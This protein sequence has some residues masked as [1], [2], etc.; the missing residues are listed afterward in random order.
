MLIRSPTQVCRSRRRLVAIS[1]VAVLLLYVLSIGPAACLRKSVDTQWV[2][3]IVK[4]VYAPL[5]LLEKTVLGDIIAEYIEIFTPPPELNSEFRS[6]LI[7]KYIPNSTVVS[8]HGAVSVSWQ[9]N[10]YSLLNVPQK[11]PQKKGFRYPALSELLTD[12]RIPVR[13]G[14]SAKDL[15][16]MSQILLFGS[17]LNEDWSF[18][19][20]V[21]TGNVW[22]VKTWYSGPP[23]NAHRLTSEVLL[24]CLQ[25]NPSG[26]AT[27]FFIVEGGAEVLPTKL[28]P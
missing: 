17:G 2:D 13:D 10:Q 12:A 26:L 6:P 4:V 1:V 27:N 21:Q 9:G 25:T 7:D 15:V 18:A 16:K 11:L 3:C 8:S 20:T 14:Q 5:M 24:Y 19:E 22:V 23:D 28:T